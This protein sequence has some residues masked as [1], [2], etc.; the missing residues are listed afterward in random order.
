MPVVILL[1]GPTGSGKST[2]VNH[3]LSPGRNMAKV[4]AKG[5]E[6][7]CTKTCARYDIAVD[8]NDYI[9]IDTPGFENHQ[10]SHFKTL[11]R[12]SELQKNTGVDPLTIT[13]AIYFHRITDGKHSGPLRD[14]LRIFREMC[15]EDFF[16]CVAFVTT[17]WDILNKRARE[18][19]YEKYNDDLDRRYLRFSEQG[20]EIFK[21]FN[22]RPTCSAV[23][24]HFS[25]LATSS[26]GKRNELLLFKELSSGVKVRWTAAGK[27]TQKPSRGN[28]GCIIL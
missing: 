21:C 19:R 9:L 28:K 15:G 10:P 2:F 8:G 23:V 13:G 18:S 20:P 1:V 6:K 5:D 14:D 7:P 24:R 26:G 22:D 11:T 25:K 4:G 3:L 27:I 17:T 12:I 16:P